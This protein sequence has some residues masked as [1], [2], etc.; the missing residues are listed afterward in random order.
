[1]EVDHN[2]TVLSNET[3]CPS[4]TF[5]STLNEPNLSWIAF[6]ARKA[7]VEVIEGDQDGVEVKHVGEEIRIT[8]FTSGDALPEIRVRIVDS[9]GHSPAFLPNLRLR[10]T[11]VSLD[12]LFQ[13]TISLNLS[14]GG[15]VL[16]SLRGY[17]RPGN[18]TLRWN[19]SR[20]EIPAVYAVVE[21]RNCTVGEFPSADGVI[22]E[23]CG[24]NFFRFVEAESTECQT[25]PTHVN[26]SARFTFPENGYWNDHPCQTA[27]KKCLQSSACTDA[28]RFNRLENIIRNRQNCSY[29]DEE[30]SEYTTALC[31][32]VRLL[33][34]SQSPD[35]VVQRGRGIL[36]F[37]VDHARLDM[38]NRGP[39]PVA[40]VG[41]RSLACVFLSRLLCGY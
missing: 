37:F 36:V 40:N 30:L 41:V 33:F 13:G 10:G 7:E 27:I 14:D 32:K 12:G 21:V 4:W 25:C 31:S 23:Q 1:M 38:A 34:V 16:T 9:F 5:N 18:Y 17:G 19:F 35:D 26:C 6:R 22:C 39:L 11:L 3:V 8:N 15:N 29:E 28:E 2:L 20:N 24:G